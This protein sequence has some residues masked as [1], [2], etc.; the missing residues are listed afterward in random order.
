V[1][2]ALPNPGTP[3]VAPS[4]A[5]SPEIVVTVPDGPARTAAATLSC[6]LHGV[7]GGAGEG[8]ELT[9]VVEAGD[10]AGDPDLARVLTCARECAESRGLVLVVR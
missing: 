10:R 3:G 2:T 4:G 7:I 1:T 8:A 9:V 5:H 6:R